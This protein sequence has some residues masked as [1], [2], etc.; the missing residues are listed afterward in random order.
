MLV[1]RLVTLRLLRILVAQMPAMM[2]AG[3]GGGTYDGDDFSGCD[4]GCG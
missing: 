1:V 4:G 3:V 2:V